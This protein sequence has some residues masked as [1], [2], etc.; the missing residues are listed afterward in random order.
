MQTKSPVRGLQLELGQLLAPKLRIVLQTKSPVRGLQPSGPIE[1]D[2]APGGLE[3]QTK[4]PVRGLQPKVLSQVS[5]AITLVMLQTKSPV[6]GL[7]PVPLHE[8]RG[9]PGGL[10]ANK[11]PRKGIATR[12]KAEQADSPLILEVANKKPRKGIATAPDAGI[13]DHS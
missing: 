10:V 13:P 1:T 6:R 4:S 2:L 9:R 8:G 7:Q 5:C 12:A 3:L 11:K